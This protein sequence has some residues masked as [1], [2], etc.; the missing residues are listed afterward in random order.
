M[1]SKELTDKE[2]VREI[3]KLAIVTGVQQLLAIP[4]IE[5]IVSM[6]I[7]GSKGKMKLR[8]LRGT[9]KHDG[10]EMPS[11]FI[12]L[13]NPKTG[14]RIA[15]RIFKYKFPDPENPNQI[16]IEGFIGIVRG[17]EKNQSLGYG[18]GLMMCTNIVIED[19]IKRY[20]EFREKLVTARISDEAQSVD[21]DENVNRE[22]WT[23]Y[24]AKQ[25]GY[26]EIKKGIWERVY[27]YAGENK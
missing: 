6:T 26:T 19:A 7:L 1:D 16:N 24:F 12:F 15:Q 25:L 2:Q 13:T 5:R 11:I 27:Q 10:L 3:N 20:P 4:D 9:E 17:G 14:K 18:S 23:S 8:Y 22:G 21:I